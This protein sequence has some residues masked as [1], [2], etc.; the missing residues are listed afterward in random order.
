MTSRSWWTAPCSERSRRRAGSIPASNGARRRPAGLI[1]GEFY[2]LVAPSLFAEP[3]VVVLRGAHEASKELA[4]ALIG[5]RADPVEGV[6][7]VVHH[8]GGAR[9]KALAD[10][11]AKARRRS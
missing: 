3:R 6:V 11:I 7:L 1:P 8:A 9:N 2:D 4:E 10:A 5:L